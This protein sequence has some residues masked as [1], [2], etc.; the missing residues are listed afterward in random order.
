MSTDAHLS[1]VFLPGLS[2]TVANEA[3]QQMLEIQATNAKCEMIQ[4]FKGVSPPTHPPPL[5]SSYFTSGSGTPDGSSH[6]LVPK[7]E[8]QQV[9]TQ[10]TQK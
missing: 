6:L 5:P 4:R 1:L 2:C 8:K 10:H 7:R 9:L 3:G